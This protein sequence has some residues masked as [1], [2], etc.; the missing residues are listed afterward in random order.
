MHD[1]RLQH[2]GLCDRV[3]DANRAAAIIRPGET[4][5]MSVPRHL[6]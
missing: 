5:A 2:P 1:T 4:V 6:I 3:V